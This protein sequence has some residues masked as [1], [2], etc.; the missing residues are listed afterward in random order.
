MHFYIYLQSNGKRKWIGV[1]WVKNPS[2][3]NTSG[4]ELQCMSLRNGHSSGIYET[5]QII[6][7][8][9]TQ[10]S[11]T[12]CLFVFVLS[13]FRTSISSS[14][15]PFDS[16]RKDPS[17][18]I[19]FVCSWSIKL[20]HWAS[21]KITQKHIIVDLRHTLSSEPNLESTSWRAW[22]KWKVYFNSGRL[23]SSPRLLY[24]GLTADPSSN[25]Y[26]KEPQIRD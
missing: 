7:S 2:F 3:E 18:D 1:W 15:A 11:I 17:S 19:L 9:S 24:Q 14:F 8:A 20:W 13:L 5:T 22:K 25:R 21:K 10:L 4:F 6:I 26:K 23:S 16:S 12:V